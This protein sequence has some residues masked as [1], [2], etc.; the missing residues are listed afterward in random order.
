MGRTVIPGEQEIV[1]KAGQEGP[2]NRGKK[3][4]QC[5]YDIFT[6]SSQETRGSARPL[7]VNDW[8]TSLRKD[9][10]MRLTW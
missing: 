3:T 6:E 4:G 9:P 2:Q 7:E 5:N 10:R 1:R 8:L